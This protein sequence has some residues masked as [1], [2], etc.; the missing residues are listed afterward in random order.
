MGA[1]EQVDIVEQFALPVRKPRPRVL[2]WT[3][4]PESGVCHK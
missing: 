4:G 3:R 2:N 1:A